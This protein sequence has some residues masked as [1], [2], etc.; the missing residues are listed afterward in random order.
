VDLKSSRDIIFRNE[1]LFHPKTKP[2]LPAHK[3]DLMS[4]HITGSIR[5]AELKTGN[6]SESAISLER[7][8]YAKRE[9][10]ATAPLGVYFIIIII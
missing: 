5:A 1:I 3:A 7:L 2:K 10:H 4:L 6:L 9:R 8:K